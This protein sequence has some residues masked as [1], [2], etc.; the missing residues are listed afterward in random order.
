MDADHLRDPATPVGACRAR[1]AGAAPLAQVSDQVF[2][3][4]AFGVRVDRVVEG[5]AGDLHVGFIGPHGT[6]CPR[7][8]LR[9][10]QPAEHVRDHGPQRAVHVELAR[11]PSGDA[12]VFAG[13]LRN[14][15]RIVP[16]R[17]IAPQLAAQRGRTTPQNRANLPQA[18]ALLAQRRQRH[19]IFGLQL[20]VSR[21]QPHTLSVGKA[22]Y[23]GVEAAQ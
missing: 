11:R 16:R 21:R 12:P 10:P 15:R 19:A 13:S 2:A 6:Q 3:Q 18:L 4:L 22:L 14:A 7:D 5:L 23:F 20:P 9:R 17:G 8:L 1:L